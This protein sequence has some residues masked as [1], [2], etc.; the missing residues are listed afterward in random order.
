[1][2]VVRATCPTRAPA[3]ACTASSTPSTSAST[4]TPSSRSPTRAASTRPSSSPTSRASFTFHVPRPENWVVVSNAPT[5][6]PEPRGDGTRAVALPAAPSG[7]RRTSPRSSPGEYHAEHATYDGQ[8]GHI[9]LGHYCRQSLV[10]H[11]DTDA[12]GRAH[13]PGLRLLRGGLRLPLP[14]PQV[15][16]ALRAGVQHGR[17]GERRRRDPARRV[18]PAQPPGRLVLRV[19]RPR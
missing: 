18:P 6:E 12:A 5:P 13:P 1:M 16:P 3:R 11:M 15:R 8:F 4:P 2:L 9:P 10:E 7:C 17:D 19:P 14:V